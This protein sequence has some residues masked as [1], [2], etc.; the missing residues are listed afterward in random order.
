M[1]TLTIVESFPWVVGKCIRRTSE[2][3][4]GDKEIIFYLS[5]I[6]C[7]VMGT[8]G[9]DSR[10]ITLTNPPIGRV[11]D[12]LDSPL[13][14]IVASVTETADEGNLLT[15]AILRLETLNG[16]VLFHWS[17]NNLDPYGETVDSAL[18]CRGRVPHLPDGTELRR[19]DRIEFAGPYSRR[20]GVIE[21]IDYAGIGKLNIL[22]DGAGTTAV[23]SFWILE[24]VRRVAD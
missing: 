22:F 19:G 13:R 5:E 20:R 18:I 11:T 24:K 15:T 9:R 12:I 21:D 10:V 16:S 17:G 7:L 6:E 23:Y 2:I 4:L 3:Q 1:K 8:V 14:E